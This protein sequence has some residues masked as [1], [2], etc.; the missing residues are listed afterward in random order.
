ML[1]TNIVLYVWSNTNI[2]TIFHIFG[3]LAAEA[4]AFAEILSLHTS[5]CVLFTVTLKSFHSV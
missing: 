1:R 4:V 3:S 5:Y 2:A